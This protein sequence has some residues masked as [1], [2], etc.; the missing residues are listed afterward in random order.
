MNAIALPCRP[1]SARTKPILARSIASLF[2]PVALALATVTVPGSSGADGSATQNGGILTDTLGAAGDGSNVTTTTS[3]FAI[4][5][6]GT[7]FGATNFSGVT[8][9]HVNFDSTGQTAEFDSAAFSFTAPVTITGGAADD[10][11]VIDGNNAITF[12]G[13]TSTYGG[14]TT[15]N[16]GQVI[17]NNASALGTGPVSLAN[18]TELRGSGT[19]AGVHELFFGGAF[20]GC[21]PRLR[22]GK[23][24]A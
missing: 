18:G 5:A 16:A 6:Q 15:V 14:G 19:P 7:N 10:Q 20:R 2:A 22:S 1:T 24:P 3:G 12:T 8:Q 21:Y 9:I 11:V 17:F 23:P 4:Q 13:A